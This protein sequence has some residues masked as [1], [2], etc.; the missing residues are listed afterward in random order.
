MKL[1][2]IINVIT[3]NLKMKVIFKVY[4]A[5]ATICGYKEEFEKTDISIEYL[6]DTDKIDIEKGLKVY[7]KENLSQ[8]IE[9][10]E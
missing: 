8:I 2:D 4:G 5:K 7:G 10:Y 1:A 9:D 3:G 6:T